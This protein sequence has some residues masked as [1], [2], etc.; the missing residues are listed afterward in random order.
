M[1]WTTLNMW[2]ILQKKNINKT[3]QFTK[4]YLA[5]VKKLIL[6]LETDLK[7]KSKLYDQPAITASNNK[8]T[9]FVILIIGFTAGPA[10]S[11]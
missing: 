3:I 1:I 11:L 2:K 10:V 9:I 7:I 5:F 6:L 4:Y 8:A